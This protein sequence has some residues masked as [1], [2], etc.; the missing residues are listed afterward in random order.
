MN[1]PI[2]KISECREAIA[3][4]LRK[5]EC[6]LSESSFEQEISEFTSKNPIKSLS[7]ALLAGFLIGSWWKQK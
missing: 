7:I 2:D 4:D 5:I 3:N 1:K 6:A